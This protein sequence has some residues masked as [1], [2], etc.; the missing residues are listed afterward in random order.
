MEDGDFVKINFEMR[1]GSD[2]QLVA[3]SDEKLA[4]ES[5]IYDPDQKYG[6]GVLIVGSQDIF[7]EIN[8]SLKGSKV[9]E[10]HEVEIK[11][12][13]AYGVRDSKNLKV[14]TV[15]E[16]KRNNIDPIPGQD[17]RINNK[18][19][20]V[21]SVSPGRVVVDY[22][23]PWSGK[24]VFYK[25]TIKDKIEGKEDK[26]KGLLE[27]NFSSAADKFVVSSE[28]DELKILVPEELKFSLEWF[29]AKYRV[30][31]A[32][33]KNIKGTTL[34]IVEKYEPVKEE[35]SMEETG[36][37]EDK[38]HNEQKKAESTKK[39]S[40]AKAPSKST[41]KKPVA[42]EGETKEPPQKNTPPQ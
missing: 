22:N 25:Y 7:K 26:L 32:L 20:R 16:F 38:E 19:G 4:K 42:K 13:D 8:E 18:R 37:E 24:D 1:V 30:V 29:D 14:H 31:E 35:P 27:M 34:S 11:A 6:E 3:T 17:I 2:R 23:H 41:K 21:L 40:S 33:R 15:A 5:N 10:E 36:K 9:G 39:E 28:G 12:A